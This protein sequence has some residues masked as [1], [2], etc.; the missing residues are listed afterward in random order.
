MKKRLQGFVAGALSMLLLT[1][2]FAFAKEAYETIS[3]I[4]NNIKIEIDGE[5]LIAKDANGAIVEPFIYNGT[6]YLPVRAIAEAFDKDVAWDEETYTVSLTTKG[7]I[8]DVNEGAADNSAFMDIY[9]KS[10]AATA[11]L[12]NYGME[13]TMDYE[14]SAMGETQSMAN[15]FSVEIDDS[16]MYTATSISMGGMDLGKTEVYIDIE[17]AVQYSGYNGQ[18][19]K[20]VLDEALIADLNTADFTSVDIEGYLKNMNVAEATVTEKTFNGK[21]C[22]EISGNVSM[23]YTEALKELDMEELTAAFEAEG[24]PANFF[25]E[26]FKDMKPFQMVMGVDKETYMPLYM[27]VDMAEMLEDVMAKVML[28]VDTEGTGEISIPKYTVSCT[29]R[30]FGKISLEIPE[31]ALNA[32]EE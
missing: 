14:M 18:W 7:E 25:E 29:F 3:V 22:Y 31:A 8:S 24:I 20:N 27:T 12:T 1:G 17:N 9:T 6:T 23:D 10:A 5:E 13:C 21:A 30:D 16:I 4:Y 26:L 32:P 28:L 15:E 19:I 2:A 11:G